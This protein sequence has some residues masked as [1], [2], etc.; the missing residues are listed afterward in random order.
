MRCL[1]NSGDHGSCPFLGNGDGQVNRETRAC[2]HELRQIDQKVKLSRF[3]HGAASP[4]KAPGFGEIQPFQV[5]APAADADGP[6]LGLT[7]FQVSPDSL[8]AELRPGR[9]LDAKFWA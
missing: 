9:R 2:A 4:L 6:Q 1:Q 3:P 7:A 5:R 8:G